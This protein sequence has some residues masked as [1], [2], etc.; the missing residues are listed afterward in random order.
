MAQE[1]SNAAAVTEQIAREIAED[2]RVWNECSARGRE[3]TMRIAS[4]VFEM[5]QLLR[6]N[7]AWEQ[8][9]SGIKLARSTG[10]KLVELHHYRN[11]LTIALVWRGTLGGAME[12]F[13]PDYLK[14]VL[15]DWLKAEIE[16]A[17]ALPLQGEDKAYQ[18]KWAKKLEATRKWLEKQAAKASGESSSD[19]S[20]EDEDEEDAEGEQAE[21]TPARSRISD[22]RDARIE[23]LE[24]EVEGWREKHRTLAAEKAGLEQ[25]LEALRKRLE[26]SARPQKAG[27]PVSEAAGSGGAGEAT[28]EAA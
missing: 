24:Q 7:A 21:R 12:G 2:L 10:F 25:Q 26:R 6:V 22:P 15:D 28:R 8:W 27:N 14:R 18:S 17:A 3:A 19:G 23:E 1:S 4:R 11:A 13:G 5:K 9:L 20:D 16:T